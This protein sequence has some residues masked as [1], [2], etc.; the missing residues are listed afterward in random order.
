MWVSLGKSE[1]VLRKIWRMKKILWINF[2]RGQIIQPRVVSF[3]APWLYPSV[4]LK[5]NNEF[6]IFIFRSIFII[7]WAGLLGANNVIRGCAF[8]GPLTLGRTYR[9]RWKKNLIIFNLHFR[10]IFIYGDRNGIWWRLGS[11]VGSA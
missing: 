8:S 7:L 3:L 5:K 9:G 2:A 1:Q 10:W 4:P 6:L 11:A